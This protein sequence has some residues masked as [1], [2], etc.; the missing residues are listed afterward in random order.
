[1]F[2]TWG[3]FS[4]LSNIHGATFFLRTL[5][6][7]GIFRTLVY[8]KPE[9]YWEPSQASTLNIFLYIRRY[10]Y[11]EVFYS[12]T[13][14]TTTY[15]DFWYIQ[16][17]STFRTQDIRYR[18]SLIYTSPSILRTRGIW[19]AVFHGTLCNIGIFRTRGIFA[20]LPNIYYEE[21][22]SEPCVTLVYLKLWHIQN[23]RHIQNTVKH[24]LQN[25]LFKT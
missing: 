12:E 5:C 3:I 13:F 10:T 6:N 19:W 23:L 14:A 25:I 11:D 15:L 2:R 20:T 24:L 7:P 8:S 9:E 17:P 16:N 21:F 1:M 4:I 18:E 22:Y